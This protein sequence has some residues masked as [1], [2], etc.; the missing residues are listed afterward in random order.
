MNT[1]IAY[2]ENGYISFL[3]GGNGYYSNIKLDTKVSGLKVLD[4]GLVIAMPISPDMECMLEILNK[5]LGSDDVELNED[6]LKDTF[7]PTLYNV[8]NNLMELETDDDTGVDTLYERM[9]VSKENIMY[10]INYDFDFWYVPEMIAIGVEQNV[11]N[12]MLNNNFLSDNDTK[13]RMKNLIQV[14]FKYRKEKMEEFYYLNTK[15]LKEE[16]YDRLYI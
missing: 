11:I 13:L 4:N 10:L 5:K 15:D 3:S 2:K 7:I 14:A 6:Y 9:I 12:I 8:L 16:E 1:I